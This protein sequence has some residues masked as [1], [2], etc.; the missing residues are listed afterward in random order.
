MKPLI[1][2][3]AGDYREAAFRLASGGQETYYA[4]KYCVDAIAALAQQVEE[5]GFLCGVTDEAYNE[6]LP[7]GV[8]AI[9]AGF[10]P[11]CFDSK[12]MI[13]LI[14]AYQP[15]HL[16]VRNVMHR[17]IQW[18]IHNQVPTITTFPDSVSLQGWQNRI[19]NYWLARLLNHDCVEWVGCYGT[20]ASFLFQQIGVNPNKIVPWYWKA[21]TTPQDFPV[22]AH[23]SG[24][25][26][27]LLYVGSLNEQKGVGDLLQAVALL[28]SQQLPIRLQLVGYDPDGSFQQRAAQLQIDDCVDFSGPLPVSALWPLM[29]AADTVIVP[30]RHDYP[31]GFPLVI[32]HTLC[33]R[34]PI[35]VS[36]HPMFRTK[37]Q[38]GL[39]GLVF[40]ATDVVALAESIRMLMAEPG[41]YQ[42]LSHTSAQIWEWLQLPVDWASLV[43][44]WLFNYPEPSQWLYAHRL[45]CGQYSDRGY[46]GCK[47]PSARSEER[48]TQ[49]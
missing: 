20:D 30:S 24:T 8:R 10:H 33:S 37:I 41:L 29:H 44:K 5:I 26:W 45:A 28:R 2:Q 35:I 16:I 46:M 49:P 14:E 15:T 34:T 32:D 6:V 47:Q 40:P 27:Q 21:T 25:A 7:N 4:Q 22:K 13:R 42:H 31:E 38:S 23:P 1:V 11:D 12:Q 19:K 17:V 3:Y 36:D 18:A 43:S 39:S 9:G 48:V